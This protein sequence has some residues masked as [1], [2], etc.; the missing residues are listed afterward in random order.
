M[1]VSTH[2]FGIVLRNPFNLITYLVVN[3][4]LE[5]TCQRTP[6]RFQSSWDRQILYT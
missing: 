4:V 1:Q 3:Q 2:I 5:I 6:F